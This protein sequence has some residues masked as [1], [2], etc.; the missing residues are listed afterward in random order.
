VASTWEVLAY[1]RR[2]PRVVVAAAA[3]RANIGTRLGRDVVERQG[4]S[5]VEA[6]RR[7]RSEARRRA[8]LPVP[9]GCHEE[10]RAALRAWLGERPPC[11]VVG[12]VALP[13]EV[14]VT[15]LHDTD[16]HRWGLVRVLSGGGLSVGP[17]DGVRGVSRYGTVEPLEAAGTLELGAGDVVLVPGLA[18][19][20]RGFRLGRGGGHYDRFLAGLPAGV[21]TVAVTVSR[22]VVA[23]LPVEPH[24]RP[25]TH[26]C[27]EHGC[28]AV[29]TPTGAG[30]A[31]LDGVEDEDGGPGRP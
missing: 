18:F 27:T 22:A 31:L 1:T 9:P 12:Y 26:V 8:A 19:D 30:S 10:V 23:D 24:D 13:D 4:R 17:W 6:K 5:V 2:R 7:A 14:D 16:R 21:V 29:P 25:V 20:R 15:P 11:T 3:V 28:S